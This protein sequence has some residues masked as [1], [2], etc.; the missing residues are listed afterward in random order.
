MIWREYVLRIFIS[1]L[2]ISK[3]IIEELLSFE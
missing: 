2:L 3:K 1:E